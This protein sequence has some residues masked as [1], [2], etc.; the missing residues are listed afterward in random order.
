M[1]SYFINMLTP[2]RGSVDIRSPP[3]TIPSAMQRKDTAI[4]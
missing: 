2:L 3:A 4:D 1:K